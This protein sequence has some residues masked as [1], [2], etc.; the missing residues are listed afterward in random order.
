MVAVLKR[1][2][3]Q[4]Q[5][6]GIKHVVEPVDDVVDAEIEECDGCPACS[7]GFGSS[8]AGDGDGDAGADQDREGAAVGEPE[9]D[10]AAP[11]PEHVEYFDGRVFPRGAIFERPPG[12]GVV[13]VHVHLHEASPV[14]GDVPRG[15]TRVE[16]KVEEGADSSAR[17][18]GFSGRAG[19]SGETGHAVTDSE[20]RSGTAG[21]DFMGIGV[22]R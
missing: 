17:S 20:G 12:S 5:A 16:L 8:V 14:P 19:L 15:A 13:H 10:E 11:A 6:L 1:I 4:L 21:A 22:V 2:E 9:V 3:E 7:G 18:V